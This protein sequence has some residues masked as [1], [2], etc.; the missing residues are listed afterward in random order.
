MN[1]ES[2]RRRAF[3]MGRTHRPDIWRAVAWFAVLLAL[4]LVVFDI[5]AAFLIDADYAV[6]RTREVAQAAQK[7]KALGAVANS[8][9]NGKAEHAVAQ[10]KDALGSGAN[11]LRNVRVAGFVNEVRFLFVHNPDGTVLPLAI[12]TLETED[13]LMRRLGG[14]ITDARSELPDHVGS[15]L[16]RV[17]IWTVG[18]ALIS[19][20]YCERDRDSR[21]ICV[22]FDEITLDPVLE[23][24]LDAA[25]AQIDDRLIILRDPAGRALWSHGP[26]S[27]STSTITELTGSMRG[28]H[29]E[30]STPAGTHHGLLPLTA[31]TIPLIG[32]WLILVWYMY[33]NQQARLME[34]TF[35]SEM[36]AKLSHDLRTP[37]ANLRLYSE[38][39]SRRAGDEDAVRRYSNVMSAEIDRLA[40]LADNTIIYGRTAAPAPIRL[41]E[42]VPDSV[43]DSTIERYQNLFAATG[44]TIEVKHGAPQA[45]RFDRMGFERILINLLDNACKYAPGRIEV[46]TREQE[47]MLYLSVRDQGSGLNVDSKDK[48]LTPRRAGA[49]AKDGFGLGLVVVRELAQTNG[50]KLTIEPAHPGVCLTASLKIIVSASAQGAKCPS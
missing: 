31:I 20:V 29:M 22:V 49:G 41:E 7:V 1:K 3:L 19:F 33:R 28:W 11:A 26:T 37:I 46:A 35:R 39:I 12:G 42:A 30:T 38:L 16:P 47:G 10:I 25:T 5:F 32:C 40:L 50:G 43:L 9:I 27:L 34:S 48:L 8:A 45:G 2:S 18:D 24:A 23:V 21:D 13:E 17:G 4:P 36:T 44:S 6:T 15:V 14:G